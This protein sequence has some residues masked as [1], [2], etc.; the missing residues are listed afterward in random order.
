MDE[1]EQPSKRQYP[2]QKVFTFC[3]VVW[4]SEQASYQVPAMTVDVSRNGLAVLL[5][6][7]SQ[8]IWQEATI[9]ILKDLELRAK[10][11]HKQPW[12]GRVDG[13]QVGFEIKLIASGASQWEAICNGSNG[14]HP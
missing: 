13:T 2:R 11:V 10:P 14:S 4:Y 7:P 6:N 5:R 9:R 12:A 1:T 3:W 8:L